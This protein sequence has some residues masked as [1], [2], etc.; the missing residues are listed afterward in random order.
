MARAETADQQ[1]WGGN[2]FEAKPAGAKLAY[3]PPAAKTGTYGRKKPENA[4]IPL[5]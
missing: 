1:L 2:E 3:A 5:F 4:R